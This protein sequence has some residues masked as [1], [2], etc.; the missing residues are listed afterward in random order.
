MIKL[1]TMMMMMMMMRTL[2]ANPEHL[3]QQADHHGRLVQGHQ[4]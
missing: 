2:A 4:R 1:M 3:D